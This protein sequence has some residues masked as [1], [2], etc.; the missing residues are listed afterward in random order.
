M[1]IKTLLINAFIILAILTACG[2]QVSQAQSAEKCSD[3][4][5]VVEAFYASNDA[6][7]YAKSLQYLAY[8]VSLVTWGDGTNGDHV[9]AN[10]AVGLTQ[11]QAFLGKPGLKRTS[12]GPDLPNYTMQDIQLSDAKMTFMLIPDRHHPNGRPYNPYHVEIFFSGCKI[13]L[14]KVVERV[15][16]L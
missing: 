3:I 5:S 7:Q 6:S 9:A 1:K 8:D 2:G 10:F 16:W 12:N 15:L 4:Q 13:E 11:I 14:L